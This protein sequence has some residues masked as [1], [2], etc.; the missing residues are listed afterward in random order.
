MGQNGFWLAN[1]KAR[2]YLKDREKNIYFIK[3][4]LKETR[5]KNN[6]LLQNRDIWQAVV[7]AVTNLQAA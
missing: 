4:S 5:W 2:D 7:S 1:V 6:D 3:T